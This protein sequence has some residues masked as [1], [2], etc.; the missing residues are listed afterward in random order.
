MSKSAAITILLITREGL[1]RGDL[2]GGPQVTLQGVWKQPR[3]DVPDLAALVEAA[4]HLGPRPARKVLVLTS[5][6]WTQT[7]ELPLH[8]SADV[9]AGDLAR[10]LNFEAETLSGLSAFEAVVHQVPLG[11]HEG[12]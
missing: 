6:L 2:S 12:F 9:N 1:V 5:D 11:T 4:L 10:A 3:P 7:L 8:K